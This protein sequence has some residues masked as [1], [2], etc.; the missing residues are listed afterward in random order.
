MN[1]LLKSNAK[2][3]VYVDAANISRSG[4][5]RMQ[6]DVLREFACRDH[7]E[8][9]RL[10]VYLSYDEERADVNPVYRDK[11][12]AYQS[13]LREIGYKVIEKRVKWY[14]DEAG[15]RFGKANADL[16]MAVD[17]LLQSENLDR[18]LLV[19][20]DGDFVQVVRALQN[21]GC[22]VETLAFDNVSEELRRESDL[23]ISGHLVPGL[24]PTRNDD[25]S[26]PPWGELGSRVRGYCYHH[27]DNKSFG[28]MRFLVKLSPFLWKTDSRDEDSPYR[29]AF[30]HDS[31]L[32]EGFNVMKLP[33]R[34]HIFE[35]SLAEPNGKQPL[36]ADIA[37]VHPL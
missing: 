12:R 37:L 10:N 8:A 17:L 21:K 14:V 20:G 9:L 2:V 13:A 1:Y 7:A 19:T 24:L 29:T 25:P 16:D 26:V 27:D 32:P 15:N 36:A 34:N 4:G 6:Y 28:F 30:F 33:S 18:V 5:Q 3:G 22:R 31:S 23:F 11:A 35:F